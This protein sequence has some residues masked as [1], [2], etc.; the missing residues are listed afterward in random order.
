MFVHVTFDYTTC[1]V[2]RHVVFY[3]CHVQIQDELEDPDLS[4]FAGSVR[5]K[6][7]KFEPEKSTVN[8]AHQ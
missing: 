4:T 2:N 6:K 5:R 8:L 7:S 1:G 3:N